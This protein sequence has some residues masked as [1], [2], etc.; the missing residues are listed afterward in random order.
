MKKLRTV[1][2]LFAIVV[3]ACSVVNA[4]VDKETKAKKEAAKKFI[5]STPSVLKLAVTQRKANK[6][7]KAK[8]DS[9]FIAKAYDHQKHA[10]ELYAAGTY[11]KAMYH[12]LKARKLAVM[13][14]KQNKGR[15]I[16]QSEPELIF[17]AFK[18]PTDKANK[19]FYSAMFKVFKDSGSADIGQWESE[20]DPN[21]ELT[22][23]DSKITAELLKKMLPVK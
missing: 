1:L 20:L 21:V 9:T 16:D 23:G 5:N 17:K 2:M 12:S 3:L 19:E 11:E 13:A 4:Q 10:M 6:K 15:F 18:N 14:V 7:I 22:E 8:D